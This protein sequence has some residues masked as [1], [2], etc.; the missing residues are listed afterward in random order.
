MKA[1]SEFVP[2]VAVKVQKCPRF[3]IEDIAKQM[4]IQFYEESRAW[5]ERDVTIVAATA[6]GQAVYTVTNPSNTELVGLPAVWIDSVEV[7]E[8]RGADLDDSEP[9]KQSSTAGVMVISPTQVRVS[10][11]PDAAARVIKATVA[12]KPAASAAGLDDLLF[13]KHSDVIASKTI[14]ELLL[15]PDKPWSNAQA[16]GYYQGKSNTDGLTASSHE[17]PLRRT[18]LRV[19]LS[20]Y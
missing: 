5:R 4:A 14:A 3:T 9:G 1:W 18:P 7:K 17:G 11:A 19:K 2:L 10:P 13:A 8:L 15:M 16:A 6:L 12:Y 20:S